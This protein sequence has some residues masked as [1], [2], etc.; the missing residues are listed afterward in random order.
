[1]LL[2]FKKRHN[3]SLFSKDKF[4]QLY[5]NENSFGKTYG[6]HREE[7]ELNKSQIEALKKICDDYNIDFICTP[8]DEVSLKELQEINTKIFK[9]ASFDMGNLRLISKILNNNVKLVLSTGGSNLE[10]IKKTISFASTLSKNLTLLHCVSNYP[11]L[12][13]ELQLYKIRDFKKIFP[14]V[15]IGLSDHFNGPL[16]GPIGLYYGAEVFEKHVT[17]NRAWKGTDHSF[18]LSLSGFEQFVKDINR[19]HSMG[20]KNEKDLKKILVK[21]LFFRNLENH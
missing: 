8:F 16:S 19:S 14:N 20:L 4:N 11:A 18:A 3:L 5:E 12:A 10:I 7:L 15:Q 17:F 2:S 9:V 6:L 13:E 21:N 1:M